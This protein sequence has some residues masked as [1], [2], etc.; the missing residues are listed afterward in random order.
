MENSKSSVQ[1]N[2]SITCKGEVAGDEAVKVGRSE[3]MKNLV[4]MPK[5]V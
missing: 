3:V 1:H 2:Q 4:R 5:C